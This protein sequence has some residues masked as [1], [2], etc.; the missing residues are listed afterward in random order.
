[1][2]IHTRM[3]SAAYARDNYNF[4][5]CIVGVDKGCTRG[6]GPSAELRVPTSHA[7]GL[8]DVMT[9]LNNT[10]Y[11]RDICTLCGMRGADSCRH[12]RRYEPCGVC[13]LELTH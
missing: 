9:I 6:W 7:R 4:E 3:C 8:Q 12:L 2:Y 10:P 11:S 13:V 5:I 1:M